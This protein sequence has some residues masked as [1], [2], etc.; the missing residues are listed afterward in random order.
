LNHILTVERYPIGD[1][2]AERLSDFGFRHLAYVPE[3]VVAVESALQIALVVDAH[4]GAVSP[5]GRVLDGSTVSTMPVAVGI[6]SSGADPV[7]APVVDLA[8]LDFVARPASTIRPRSSVESPSIP[9]TIS[10]SLIPRSR[11]CFFLVPLSV[12]RYGR[13]ARG[14]RCPR[15]RAGRSVAARPAAA[16]SGSARGS[17]RGT[18]RWPHSGPVRRTP[19]GR[20][21]TSRTVCSSGS[22]QEVGAA[23]DRIAG[24]GAS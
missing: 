6:S 7:A 2:L 21:R 18:P 20:S 3:V 4:P 19:A 1:R 10:T 22:R 17:S 14:R 16:P 23:E 5:E 9:V 11:N 15:N 8:V 12:R 24:N 13:N